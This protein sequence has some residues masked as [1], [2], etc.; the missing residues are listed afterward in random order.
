[1]IRHGPLMVSVALLMATSSAAAQGPGGD[2]AARCP[3]W[4]IQVSPPTVQLDPE[5][6][7]RQYVYDQAGKVLDAFDWLVNECVNGM[8]C[9]ERAERIVA[10]TGKPD[11]H[12]CIGWELDDTPFDLNIF[13]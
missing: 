2:A 13:P 5:G 6:C 9:D 1:M 7:V 8:N 12:K 11:P 4:E 10:C 3:V